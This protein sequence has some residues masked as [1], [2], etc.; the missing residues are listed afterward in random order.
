[1]LLV[2]FLD[3]FCKG[4]T[5]NLDKL[6]IEYGRIFVTQIIWCVIV[7]VVSV[8]HFVTHFKLYIW[9]IFCVFCLLQRVSL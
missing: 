2:S 4:L 3:V 9:D 1:M 8:L 7:F 5:W 6:I